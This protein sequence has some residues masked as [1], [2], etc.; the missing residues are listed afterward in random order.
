MIHQL[1]EELYAERKDVKALQ[2]QKEEKKAQNSR[3]TARAQAD[4]DDVAA[5]LSSLLV[6]TG[7]QPQL[8]V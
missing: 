5:T 1:K 7:V 4:D 6:G 3:A 2:E 8:G